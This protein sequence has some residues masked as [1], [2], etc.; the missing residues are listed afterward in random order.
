M[1]YIRRDRDVITGEKDL[2]ELYTFKNFPVFMGCTDQPKERD[3]VADM[4]WQ[5]SISSGMI[6][7]NPLLPLEVVYAEEHGSGTVGDIWNQHHEAFAEFVTKFSSIKSV[8]EIGGLH[9]HLAKK[10]LAKRNLDW[11][12][13]EPNPRVPADLPVKVIKGFFD[14]KFISE[15]KY[16][17]VI[18]SH[19]L[20]H[21]YDPLTFMRH[22]SDFMKKDSLLIMSVPNLEAMLRNNYTNCLNFEHTYFASQPYVELL[23]SHFGY[24]LL[25]ESYFKEDHSIFFCAKKIRE[26][27]EE[28]YIT[29]GQR[30]QLYTRNLALFLNYTQYHEEL[31]SE[32]NKI[33]GD[34]Y[35][36]GAH[37][38]S[39][40][41]LQFGL[42]AKKIINILDNDPNKQNKRLYGTDLIV[43]SPEALRDVES[44][45]VI[46]KT[47][48]YNEEIRKQIESINPNIKVIC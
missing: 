19:V 36:F 3:I 28:I 48:V 47:G 18:H 29:S 46:V 41:L 32:L 10:S 22:I 25:E 44:G 24:E 37:I 26:S 4:S 1:N 6:Q 43:K 38:F 42:D 5:M 30:D 45:T 12:I 11:T 7:L 20:E 27:K 31:V 16:D 35:L 8:L 14:D 15:E 9:G 40:T 23:L 17:A 2:R 21:V 33:E 34:V 39:Q 13:I